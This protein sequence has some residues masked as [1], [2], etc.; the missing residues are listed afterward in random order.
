MDTFLESIVGNLPIDHLPISS[1][2]TQLRDRARCTGCYGTCRAL[3]ETFNDP[4]DI[5]ADPGICGFRGSRKL[6][7]GGF[8][9]DGR[10]WLE[11]AEDVWIL[12]G[13]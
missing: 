5:L 4:R 13:S 1:G 8:R 9:S 7:A 12:D 2:F 6:G 11:R 3:A 10:I